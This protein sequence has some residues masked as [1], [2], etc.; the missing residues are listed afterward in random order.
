MRSI[1]ITFS[2][3][4]LLSC[5]NADAPATD[6]ANSGTVEMNMEAPKEP[7]DPK[8]HV[9]PICGMEW[10]NEWTDMTVYKGDTIRFCGEG[11]KMAFEARP[12]KY[13]K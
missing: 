10:E 4:F 12:Q 7:I 13:V 8:T 5:S 3:V 11:C 9:D 6:A 2:C 1:A